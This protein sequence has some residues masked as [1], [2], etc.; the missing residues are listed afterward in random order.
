MIDWYFANQVLKHKKSLYERK[1][2][3]EI[4]YQGDSLPRFITKNSPSSFFKK[5][6]I[7]MGLFF[8]QLPRYEAVLFLT[9]YQIWI[10]GRPQKWKESKAWVVYNS[11]TKRKRFRPD[12][13]MFRG[14]SPTNTKPKVCIAF[15]L[16]LFFAS[17][18][19][20]QLFLQRNTPPTTHNL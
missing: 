17:E 12:F 19:K 3:H 10:L 20:S 5:P 14:R 4:S 7:F 8:S 16:F 11:E 18:R 1:E 13:D 9:A 2:F 15:W 6:P